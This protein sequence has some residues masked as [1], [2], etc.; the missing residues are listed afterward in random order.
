MKISEDPVMAS[1]FEL[2][3]RAARCFANVLIVG[4]SGVGK[5][6]L[7]RRIHEASPV[8]DGGFHTLLCYPGTDMGLARRDIVEALCLLESRAGTVVVEDVHNLSPQA[9]KRLLSYLDRRDQGIWSEPTRRSRLIFTSSK[10]PVRDL[11]QAFSEQLY[12]RVAVIKIEI[13][14]LRLRRWDI[15][16][17]AH[18]F[19]SQYSREEGRNLKGFTPDALEILVNLPWQGNIHELKNVINRSVVMADDGETID[20]CVLMGVLQQIVY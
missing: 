5:T 6:Y 17:L 1:V 7:A 2:V 8:A 9:Q 20:A 16:H 3:E 11:K 12:M 19:L 18:E 13:P 4:E 14:P 10:C 15:I